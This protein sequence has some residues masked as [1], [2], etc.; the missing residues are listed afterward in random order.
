MK[1]EKVYIIV[2]NYKNYKDTL[3]CLESL[4]ELKYNNF[5]IIVIDNASND[6]SSE[7]IMQWIQNYSN[8]I[9]I[10]FIESKFNLG[11][12]GGNNI[13]I[14]KALQDEEMKYVWVLNNDTIVNKEALAELVMEM[15]SDIHIGICGSKLIYNWD[16]NQIQGYGGWYHKFFGMGG[17]VKDEKKISEIDYVIGASMFFRRKVFETTGLF[18]EDYFLYFEELDFSQRIKGKFKMACAIN[19]IVFHK[20]GASIGSNGRKPQEKSMLSD[21]YLIR[22]RILFT[23]KY[24]PLYLPTVYIGLIYA[25]FNRLRRKQFNRVPMIIKLMLGIK[26]NKFERY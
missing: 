19:S 5:S 21:Y 11:Y 10:E 4:L 13:G 26:D 7:K 3:M 24:C 15:N 1:G 12:A 8:N 2:L 20:E 22:N 25:I 16:R 17:T 9:S 14:R 6:G 23:K 18:S